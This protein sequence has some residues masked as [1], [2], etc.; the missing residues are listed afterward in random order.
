MLVYPLLL[1]FYF[2]TIFFA[3]DLL[4]VYSLAE[5]FILLLTMGLVV[6]ALVRRL[7]SGQFGLVPYKDPVTI[8]GLM[9]LALVLIQMIP[10][11]PWLLEIISPTSLDVWKRAPLPE[12]SFFPISVYPYAT[13]HGLIFAFCLL[14]VYWWVLYGIRDR[15]DIEKLVLGIVVFGALVALYGLIET[16]TGHDHILWWKK[17][18]GQSMVTATFFNRN[19]L[20][21][22]LSMSLLIGIGYFWHLWNSTGDKDQTRKHKIT[23]QIEDRLK[24]LGLRGIL[25]LVSLLILVFTL[26]ATA[27][28]GGNLSTLAA[29]IFMVGLIGSR[30]FRKKRRASFLLLMTLIIAF[31][32]Y[33]VGDQLWER[34]GWEKIKQ[35]FNTING[36]S[37]PAMAN[38][39]WSLLRE[40]PLFGAGFDTF[41]FVFSRY[42]EHSPKLLDHAHNDWLELTAEIG[43]AGLLIIM[44][45]L[46]L[47]AY[48]FLKGFSAAGDILTAGL[49]LASFLSLFSISLH[50]LTDFSLHK[51]A[52]SLLL[53]LTLGIGIK[54]LF[55]LGPSHFPNGNSL[56]KNPGAFSGK[57]K[58]RVGP[59]LLAL[60]VLSGSLWG[61]RLVLYS[62]FYDRLIGADFDP[63]GERPEPRLDSIIGA[64]TLDPENS[65][66]WFWVALTIQENTNL[67][68]PADLTRIKNVALN[69]P[70]KIK[71]LISSHT[72]Q[73]LFFTSEALSRRPV[74]APYWNFLGNF[75]KNYANHDP[76]FFLPLALR[77]FENNLNF[78]PLQ[79]KGYLER[80]E[81]CLL[82]NR[83]LPPD[84]PRE[85]F[86][87]FKRA[88][89]LDPYLTPLAIKALMDNS[90][91]FKSVSELLP[92]KS[93][94]WI[95]TGE[96]L[97]MN[98]QLELGEACYLTGER[99]RVI[100]TDGL[101]AQIKNLLYARKKPQ[102]EYLIEEL[103][104]LDPENPWL[105]YA[106]GDVLKA[107]YHSLQRGWSLSRL[108]DVDQIRRRLISLIPAYEHDKRDTIFYLS[109]LDLE[110]NN[111]SQAA[112]KLDQVL[113]ES[114][115][116]F[117]ALL[118]RERLLEKKLLNEDNPHLEDRIRERIGLFSM[119][120]I[121]PGGWEAGKTEGGRKTFRASYRTQRP[122]SEIRM[123]LPVDNG[124]YAVFIDERF[125]GAREPV[126]G[127]IKI[128]LSEPLNFGE[129]QTR[130]EEIDRSFGIP[131]LKM[132]SN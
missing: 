28:R 83:M 20:A 32:T 60:I 38:D 56:L 102:A 80:G 42:A 123:V 12:G 10:F 34:I 92:Q 113:K 1:V 118:A 88:L 104:A 36:L 16:A 112:Q 109:L 122:T 100:E 76:S 78:N 46:F 130:V 84:H 40:Y 125:V 27:S 21:T 70:N 87:D 124:T 37:R 45:G 85:C 103:K 33:A 89:E 73:V 50:A 119:E 24:T 18:F 65:T 62:L 5:L 25:T 29:T 93:L 101:I 81:V 61:G 11:P 47:I 7:R 14:L 82:S 44:A 48:R 49:I 15:R 107:L 74:S 58:I 13:K 26:L 129:H 111:W 120:E 43:F 52:N 108:D 23:R 30:S 79:S 9:F 39:T 4:W 127:L 97:L 35:E 110:Q 2:T 22:F 8:F 94:A 126:K 86:S 17:A 69:D 68:N 96:Y 54:A 116:F 117:P 115:Y 132:D 75:C 77:A 59:A 53:A 3:G 95:K 31:G 6:W 71:D 63:R 51:P 128:L 64:I 67:V 131:N 72:S 98:K 55:G 105:F 19:H 121:K 41:Q 99:M 66:G 106:R 57:K 91:P 114:P 90:I